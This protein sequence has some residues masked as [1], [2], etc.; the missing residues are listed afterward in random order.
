MK[1]Y[2]SLR[3]LSFLD[4]PRVSITFGSRVLML[5]LLVIVTSLP[6]FAQSF[7]ASMELSDGKAETSRA[8]SVES[9]EHRVFDLIND[10]RI[11]NGLQPLIWTD[12]S[13]ITARFHSANMSQTSYFSHKDL[14]GNRV[15]DRLNKFGVTDWRMAGENIAWIS[16]YDDPTARV[17][18]SW[19]NSPGHRKNILQPK[20]RESGIGLAITD[21][22]KFYF[23]QVF[24][25]R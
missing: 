23:T 6:A 1:F 5:A 22:H 9:I 11:K 21:D 12:K 13:A 16:G 18:E 2:L 15:E 7:F 4:Y 14:I 20:Y 17:V 24:V 19:M 3:F 8:M 10:E 25:S